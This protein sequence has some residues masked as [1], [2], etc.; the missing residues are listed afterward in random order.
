MKAFKDVAINMTEAAQAEEQVR[1]R[2]MPSGEWDHR[3]AEEMERCAQGLGF[4]WWRA[5]G[6]RIWSV[7]EWSGV[8]TLSAV[9]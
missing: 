4:G 3:P 1:K 2:I 7:V 8:D 9:C 5:G 6:R